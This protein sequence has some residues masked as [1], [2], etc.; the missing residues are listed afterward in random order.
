[1]KKG[2][3]LIEV[4]ISIIFILGTTATV[5][6]LNINKSDRELI[7]ATNSVLEGARVF[8]NTE[9][10]GKGNLYK[11]GLLKGGNALAIPLNELY[12]KGYVTE[13]NI[14]VLNNKLGS[15]DKK[16]ILAAVFGDEQ[17]ECSNGD[18]VIELEANWAD[19]IDFS[20]SVYLCDYGDLKDGE[21]PIENF[22]ERILKDYNTGEDVPQKDSGDFS[23]LEDYYISV[24]GSKS[25][26]VRVIINRDNG[27]YKRS[28][29]TYYFRGKVYNNYVKLGNDLFRILSFNSEKMK[30][31]REESLSED[32]F[33]RA[34][35]SFS[36][37]FKTSKQLNAIKLWFAD[38]K[39][40]NSFIENI[41]Y[42]GTE[43]FCNE[44]KTSST[45][46]PVLTCDDSN[47]YKTNEGLG[48]L[49]I[50][51][52]IFAGVYPVLENADSSSSYQTCNIFN[53]SSCF[54]K[55]HISDNWLSSG[56][57]LIT[58]SNYNDS[59]YI[60]VIGIANET[61]TLGTDVSYVY[62]IALPVS[63]AKTDSIK[64][65][66]RPVL[67]IDL[68]KIDFSGNG[69]INDPYIISLKD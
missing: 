43:V 60:R 66:L 42:S 67:V 65:A 38:F 36:N 63:A 11:I 59:R 53:S 49:T 37:N 19:K 69:T 58:M 26:Y 46:S 14:E 54:G 20:E 29:N 30:I 8:L 16:Y 22:I 24:G 18:N 44:Q 13:S 40:T 7:N 55:T 17:E 48:L 27:L 6:V 45:I 23:S 3:T 34:S 41:V 28:D 31:I 56:A 9:V 10:D 12:E 57:S 21:K 52:A 4:I 39:G 61:P 15:N 25:D 1:M 2:F 51:E 64:N 33:N 5:L 35:G 47:Q 32:Y 68:N 62:G 50:D